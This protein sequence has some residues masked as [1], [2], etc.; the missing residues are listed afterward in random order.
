MNDLKIGDKVN[1]IS[2]R[3]MYEDRIKEVHM[4]LPNGKEKTIPKIE[5]TFTEVKE[6]GISGEVME[7]LP[8]RVKVKLSDTGK[9][10]I[11]KPYQLEKA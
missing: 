4:V 5:K 2:R 3:F 1:L 6:L 10:I 8:K 11:K 7:L 9:I